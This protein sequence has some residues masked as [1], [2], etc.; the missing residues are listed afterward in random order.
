MA[1]SLVMCLDDIS[2]CSVSFKKFFKSLYVSALT[3]LL[4]SKNALEAISDTNIFGADTL[5]IDCLLYLTLAFIIFESA[6]FQLPNQT[7]SSFA[8]PLLLA[9][10]LKESIVILDSE[11]IDSFSSIA[12]L[13][14]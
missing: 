10:S 3:S 8:A 1:S 5:P 12:S 7:P 11:A 4:P 14:Q 13:T 2:F 9:T 6:L